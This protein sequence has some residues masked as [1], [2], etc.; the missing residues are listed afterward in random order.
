[1]PNRSNDQHFD[2]SR[3]LVE[4]FRA[5]P[6]PSPGDKRAFVELY[7]RHHDKLLTY[8][9]WLTR[10]ADLAEDIT[11]QAFLDLLPKLGEIENPRAW[12]RTV[13]RRKWI[14]QFTKPVQPSAKQSGQPESAPG[15]RSHH[16]EWVRP[17]S[18][19]RWMR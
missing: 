3:V 6:S 1:M 11:Q 13:A 9:R 2:E 12:L 14:A 18:M 10:D 15:P 5:H 7:T 4:R 8:C 19:S 16:K 17:R